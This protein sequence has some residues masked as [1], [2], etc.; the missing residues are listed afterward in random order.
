MPDMLVK[1][2]QLPPK[3]PFVEKL[4]KQGIAIRRPIGPENYAVIEWIANHFGGG[5]AG[6]AENAFFRS[7][8]GLFIAVE[9]VDGHSKMVG[10]ACYDATAKGFFGPTGVQQD[11]R[12]RGIGAALLLAAL[13]AMREEGYGY[14]VI[15]GAGPVD[16]Y[17][18]VC[19]ATVIEGSE[20]GIYAGML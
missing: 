12:G 10:F 2:Y 17:Q 13:E 8:K 1:L 18:K 20:P 14:A 11:K 16:F 4:Q 9:Q 7:P 3:A 19:G 6:E 5:W 15:G